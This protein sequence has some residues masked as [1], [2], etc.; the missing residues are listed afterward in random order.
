MRAREIIDA[1]HDYEIAKSFE[2]EGC[3][4]GNRIATVL[5]VPIAREK[6]LKLPI[7]TNDHV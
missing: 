4:S 2:L 1:V 6:R 3:W 5:H 7:H